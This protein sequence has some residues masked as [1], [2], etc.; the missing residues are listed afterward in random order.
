MDFRL[1]DEHRML[2]ELVAP[3]FDPEVG[4]VMGRVVPQNTGSNLLTRLL[5]R[6]PSRFLG[7]IYAALSVR[8]GDAPPPGRA[9]P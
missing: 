7:A 1:S 8:P 6:R 2:R 3:F 9:I 4:A 5:A